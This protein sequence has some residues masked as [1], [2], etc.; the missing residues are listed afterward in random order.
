M[1]GG[2]NGPHLLDPT[3]GSEPQ[4]PSRFYLLVR[5]RGTTQKPVGFARYHPQV[6]LGTRPAKPSPG[7][8]RK[9]T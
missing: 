3:L 9:L 1:Q 6:L 5:G 4:T 8:V 7:R 2:E